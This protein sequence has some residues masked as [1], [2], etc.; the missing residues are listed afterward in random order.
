MIDLNKV[1]GMY[2][3][4]HRR[5]AEVINDV[6]PEVTLI[7]LEALHPAFTVERPF[8]IVHSPPFLPQYVV[9]TVAEAEIDARCA[10]ETA[11]GPGLW[12]LDRDRPRTLT[13]EQGGEAVREEATSQHPALPCHVRHLVGGERP[14]HAGKGPMSGAHPHARSDRARG[15]HDQCIVHPDEKLV[16]QKI[17][18]A[19]ARQRRAFGTTH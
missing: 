6:F 19:D 18:I 17:D 9:R 7:K 12:E 15:P 10:R 3:V 2:S 5:I 11:A 4:H 14:R 1:N 13:E 16:P 8:A